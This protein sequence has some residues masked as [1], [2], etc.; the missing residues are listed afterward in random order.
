MRPLRRPTPA[1]RGRRGKE[2]EGQEGMAEKK[3]ALVTGGGTGIGAACVRE[4]ACKGF[5]VG[6][7]YRSSADAAARLLKEI[8]DGFLLQADLTD[9]DQVEAMVTTL[10]EQTERLDCLV[11]NAGV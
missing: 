2:R 1:S 3:T 6:I 10:K 7:H 5:R 8:G 9:A 4:L 11:N